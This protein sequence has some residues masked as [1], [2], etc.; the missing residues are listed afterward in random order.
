MSPIVIDAFDSN[1]VKLDLEATEYINHL[2]TQEYLHQFN[3]VEV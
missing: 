1:G 2:A 3:N